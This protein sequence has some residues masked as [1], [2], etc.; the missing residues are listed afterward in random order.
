[1]SREAR[2]RALL[3]ALSTLLALLLAEGVVRITGAAPDIFVL[4][5]DR[6]QLSE[7][8]A[9]KYELL[10]GASDGAGSEPISE[11]GLRDR[12]FPLSKPD[13]TA[14]IVFAGDSVAYGYKVSR[15]HSAPKAL[16]KKLNG[17]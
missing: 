7:N 4:F 5:A 11:W 17:A 16:E 15:E 3:V 9:L 2:A 10:P 12:D 6:Y 13:G 1:L 8:G 14:R